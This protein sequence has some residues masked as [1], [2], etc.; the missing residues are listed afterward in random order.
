MGTQ[1]SYNLKEDTSG[2]KSSETLS[3]INADLEE[4]SAVPSISSIAEPIQT[5]FTTDDYTKEW[6]S[7]SAIIGLPN[8][9]DMSLSEFASFYGMGTSKNFGLPYDSNTNTIFISQSEVAKDPEL[10]LKAQQ[11]AYMMGAGVYMIND[12]EKIEKDYEWYT[13]NTGKKSYFSAPT[14][15]DIFN[16]YNLTDDFSFNFPTW[17]AND[18][19]TGK[20]QTLMDAIASGKVLPSNFGDLTLGHGLL[21]LGLL[22]GGV[23]GLVA[24]QMIGTI[25]KILLSGGSESAGGYKNTG[26]IVKTFSNMVSNVYTIS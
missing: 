16:H 18:D 9:S 12:V 22:T 4:S 5:D 6:K 1:Y 17:Y 20:D 26:D 15:S 23:P 25:E 10:K 21:G 7:K 24:G 14:V 8:S 19:A 11:D 13:D 3:D 2:D